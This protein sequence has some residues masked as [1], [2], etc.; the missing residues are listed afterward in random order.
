MPDQVDLAQVLEQRLNRQEPG[1]RRC[2]AEVSSPST[3]AP[4]TM[5]FEGA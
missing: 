5:S 1:G 2:G 3:G 4:A